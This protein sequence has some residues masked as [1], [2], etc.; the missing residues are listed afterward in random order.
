MT[1]WQ[2]LG[3]ERML[4]EDT[5]TGV[6][7]AGQRVLL[8]RVGDQYHAYRAK[9]PHLGS[10]LSKGALEDGVIVCSWHGSRF[11]A[12]SGK[13]QEWV[14]KLPGLV[15]SLSKVVKP[16]QDLIGYP[17]KVEDGQVWI[18]AEA[19]EGKS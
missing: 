1:R 4:D 12:L 14:P 3:E 6:D 13:Q 8:V 10:D 17:I 18:D 16:P 5:M 11:D 9:C 15:V 19:V 2:A 7:V